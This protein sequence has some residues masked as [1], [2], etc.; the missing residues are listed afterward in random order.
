MG[1]G[2]RGCCGPPTSSALHVSSPRAARGETRRQCRNCSS[3]CSSL[4]SRV[5][6]RRRRGT[7]PGAA[8]MAPVGRAPARA[9]L[10]SSPRPGSLARGN[11]RGGVIQAGSGFRPCQRTG[12]DVP[13]RRGRRAPVRGGRWAGSA[14]PMR[15]RGLGLDTRPGGYPAWP[16]TPP[17]S[18]SSRSLSRRSTRSRRL[19]GRSATGWLA[20][21][22]RMGTL[23]LNY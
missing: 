20:G 2:A 9:A 11:E 3:V 8:G 6:R 7:A 5:A 4:S 22:G 21:G 13:S 15:Q 19:R 18:T 14:A 16:G 17:S 1:C 10:P 12:T 23:K